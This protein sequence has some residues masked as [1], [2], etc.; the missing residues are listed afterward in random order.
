M[1][2]TYDDRMRC[3]HKS[4]FYQF[5]FETIKIHFA[6]IKLL[7]KIVKTLNTASS[8]FLIRLPVSVYYGAHYKHVNKNCSQNV[9][10]FYCKALDGGINVQQSNARHTT[11]TSSRITNTGTFT[12][13]EQRHNIIDSKLHVSM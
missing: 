10:Q 11:R 12:F 13:D 6:L 2:T 1:A 5:W 9:C 3:L 4:S 8:K 7:G